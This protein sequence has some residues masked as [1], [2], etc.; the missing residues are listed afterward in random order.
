[1]HNAKFDLGVLARTGLPLPEKWE[2]TML[3][4]HLLDETGN[5]G[6][7]P[8]AKEHLGIDDPMTFEEADRFRL[9]NPEIFE[10]YARNDARYTFRLWPKFEREMER[11]GLMSIYE[12]E[13]AVVPVVMEMEDAGMKLDLAQMDDMRQTVQTE[14]DA[15]ESEIYEH[16]GCRFRLHSTQQTVT[17]LFDKLGVPSN[18][19]TNGGQRSVDKGALE[20]VR[21]YHPAVDAILRYREI[22]KLASTF[23]SVLPTFADEAGRIHPEFKQLGAT[24]GRFSC[25]NPNVQQIPSRSELGKKLRIMFVADEGNSLVV[26]DWSQM[27]LRILA[28]Y[29]KDPPLLSAYQSEIETDLHTLTA[30]RMFAKAETDVSKSERAIAKA[31]WYY[32]RRKTIPRDQAIAALEAD[33]EILRNITP[34]TEGELTE[35]V[36]DWL[37]NY[38]PGNP[39]EWREGDCTYPRQPDGS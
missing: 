16:A 22:D 39:G 34:L 12:L 29:S 4:A 15:I 17:I 19:E 2:D 28:Q 5:H 11:Q 7:K 33:L 31:S 8:L 18:K 26:A 30:S 13:K 14:A 36:L 3:A 10:E 35:K 1:M 32:L 6:L 23:L 21:G 24:S 37:Q 25:A 20:A 27:E 38:T 9:L